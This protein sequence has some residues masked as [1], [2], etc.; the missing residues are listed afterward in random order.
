MAKPELDPFSL[1]NA[2]QRAG[3]LA[4]PSLPEQAAK[5]AKLWSGLGFRVGNMQFVTPLNQVSEVLS[6]P[7]VTPVPGT[8]RWLRGVANVR[9]NLLTIIDLPDYFGKDPVPAGEQARM[10]VMNIPGFNA[11][12]MVHEVLGLRHFD[13]QSERQDVSSVEDRFSPHLRGAFLRDNTLWG[14]FDLHSLAETA[15]FLH[16]AA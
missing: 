5:V 9:G 10:L 14:V 6:C 7:A 11:A 2:M 1:L 16:V 12:L 13:E 3:R 8:K 15:S 4:A